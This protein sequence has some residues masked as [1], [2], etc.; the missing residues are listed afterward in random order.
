MT[1]LRALVARNGWGSLD[2]VTPPPPQN[3]PKP[4]AVRV[5]YIDRVVERERS[6]NEIYTDFVRLV[7]QDPIYLER[8]AAHYKHAYPFAKAKKVEAFP[9]KTAASFEIA[10]SDK[11]KP[12]RVKRDRLER[13]TMRF[14]GT[15][16][17]C[18]KSNRQLSEPDWRGTIEFRNGVRAKADARRNQKEG[19]YSAA[20]VEMIDKTVDAL[21]G[22]DAMFG[23]LR[24]GT[25][26][27]GKP[28]VDGYL[29]VASYSGLEARSPDM[30]ILSLV[31][32]Q[33]LVC[34][35]PRFSTTTSNGNPLG[36]SFVM[37]CR[38][39]R[40]QRDWSTGRFTIDHL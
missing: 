26:H 10:L 23:F 39:T 17:V 24:A 14:S 36:A 12:K 25:E 5:E 29:F 11:G 9:F 3:D 28:S 35:L 15:I 21:A 1:D 7:E 40:D 19:N 37:Q 32:D 27:A 34:H 6:A 8:L 13:E 31:G 38:A 4:K 18:T 20:F 22:S 30:S 16:K 2:K 33:Q